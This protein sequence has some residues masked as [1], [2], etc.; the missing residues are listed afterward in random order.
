VRALELQRV[1]KRY[2]DAAEVICV[3]D[4]IDLSIERGEVVAV[5]G[6]SGSGK[7]T[8]LLLAAGLLAP[9]QGTVRVAGRDLRALRADQLATLQR[10][11]IG[12]VYQSPHLMSGVPAL[13][14]A[15]IKLLAERMP[16]RR[17]RPVAADWL[18]RVGLANRIS[19][20][21]EQLSGGERQR[22][23]I[24]RALVNSPGL[25]LADEPTGNLD[26]RR[27]RE[28][29]ELLGAVSRECGAAVLLA[30]HDPQAAEI[31]DQVLA[32]GDGRLRSARTLAGE[33][34]A[35]LAAIDSHLPES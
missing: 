20:T 22:V 19:H 33:H 1:V 18:E 21:P 11:E 4:G 28:I 23:A 32:L 13:E 2:S 6:P 3:A 14:N 9:D 16:L 34:P 24:A 29:L 10:N 27:A 25:V 31:A 12:F 5:Y 26:S 7:T 15:A 35:V 8:L 30:T 17:A